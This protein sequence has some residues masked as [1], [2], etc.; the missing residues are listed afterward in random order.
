MRYPGIAAVAVV[1]HKDETAAAFEIAAHQS[2]HPCLVFDEMKR[3]RHNDPV[4]IGQLEPSREVGSVDAQLS[5][6]HGRHKRGS[7]LRERGAIAIDRVDD[8]VRANEVGEREGERPAPGA[9][10]R[11]RPTLA[12]IDAARQEREM[13]RV[14]HDAPRSLSRQPSVESASVT[15]P[16]A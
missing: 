13:V 4:E 14:V 5:L 7:Q 6:R 16:S 11:P 9:Q 2:E 10:V 15:G 1:L 8:S 12:L 3:V